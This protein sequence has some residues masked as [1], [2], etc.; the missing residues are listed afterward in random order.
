M[1]ASFNFYFG[2]YIDFYQQLL[3]QGIFQDHIPG[4]RQNQ[5]HRIS[6]C[7]YH[8]DSFHFHDLHYQLH[9]SLKNCFFVFTRFDIS[10]NVSG[11][12]EKTLFV[13][14]YN[15]LSLSLTLFLQNTRREFLEKFVI[16]F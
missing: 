1:S 7:H 12:L 4:N 5:E 10:H 8:N 15:L 13:V 6:H 11:N 3:D 9:L 2:I 16:L 14:N